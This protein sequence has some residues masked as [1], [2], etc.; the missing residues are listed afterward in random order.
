MATKGA[1]NRYGNARSGSQGRITKNTGFAWAKAF[2]KSTL[3]DHFYRHGEQMGCPN[4][5]SYNA[6]AVSFAN[7]VDRKNCVSFIDKHGSTYKY[8]KVTN[9]LAIIRKN[10]IVITFYKPK[11]GYD[12]YLREKRNKA[13]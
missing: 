6:K 12:Y 3:Y 4:K 5:E 2:N 9:T 13:R 7:T 1:S 11:D 10:G 8:N